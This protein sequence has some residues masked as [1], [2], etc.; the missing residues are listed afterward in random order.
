MT[1]PCPHCG[2]LSFY[3]ERFNC[4]H[5][6]KVNLGIYPFPSQLETLFTQDTERGK[7]FRKNIRRYNTAISFSSFSA[8]LQSLP[9]RGPR[10]FRMCGQ[11][12]HNY[13]TLI[14]QIMLFLS[15][16]TS[17]ISTSSPRR[18]NFVTGGC[19][20]DIFEIIS[21]VLE[22][23]NPYAHW[24]KTMAE[25]ERNER[26]LALQE[27]RPIPII[28][29][30][31]KTGP[32]RRRY[33]PPV[34]DEVAAIFSSLDGAPQLRRD[35]VVYPRAQ[36]LSSISYLSPN[37]NPMA[38]PLFYPSGEPGWHYGIPHVQEHATAQRTTVTLLQFHIFR[39]ADRGDFN[40]LL[41]GGFL[42][43]Q[44]MVDDYLAVESSRLDFIR[45]NQTKCRVDCLR[46]L[47]DHV[48]NH[49]TTI[50]SNS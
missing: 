30:H 2:S 27:Q 8:N 21:E 50:P 17:A 25:V 37:R 6:G 7:N 49:H 32:E 1:V 4:C 3:K 5:N 13:A 23:V 14:Q 43:Q 11:I 46:G 34:H 16:L 9:G 33:N 47:Y 39:W 19:T 18:T 12:Y 45:K 24:Y 26:Q 36:K 15:V 10:V 42:T 28:T 44:K 38:Y 20:P 48:Y 22:Q 41:H 40:P 31:M 29:S 35:I